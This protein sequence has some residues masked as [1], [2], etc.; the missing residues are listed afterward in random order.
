M[1]VTEEKRFNI[2]TM[3]LAT[4][5]DEYRVAA[6]ACGAHALHDGFTDLIYVLL[7]LWQKEFGLGYTELG[8]LRA[9]FSGT[10]A[11]FQIPSGLLA[12]RLG[13]ALVLALGT[14]LSGIGYCLAGASVSLGV[15]MLALFSAG[16]GSSTQHPLASSLM[17]HAFAGERSMKAIGTYNFAGD[18][19]KMTIPAIASLLLVVLPWRPVL[20]LFGI[21]GV[22]VGLAIYILTP[23]LSGQSATEH[24]SRVNEGKSLPNVHWIAFPTLTVIAMIDSAT[25]MGFL[26]FLPFIL[27]AKG[28]SVPTIGIALTL[29][30]AGGAMG[31]LLCGFIGAR[32]GA[33]PTVWLTEGLTAALIV[34][35]L[36]L[37]LE[38]ALPLLPLIGVALNGTSSVLYGSVPDLVPPERRARAFSIFY[39]GAIGAG[40]TAPI[41]Y[42]IIGD[43][44]GMIP[45]VLMIAGLVLLTLPLSLVL[46]SYGQFTQGRSRV[47][48]CGSVVD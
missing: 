27:T 31:K 25:R 13:A 42:G 35:I 29:V 24:S 7:P 48:K 10:M 20:A 18:I 4:R 1:A 32:I 12:E 26:L 14:A 3:A 30:F 19:G 28:A 47:V 40:A 38:P 39:T 11:G 44:L 17:A 6:V 34:S 22:M 15:L 8:L 2:E 46:R 16:L 33:I 43:A 23:Q 37:T 5:R 45:A 9:M 21:L 36:P 41:L